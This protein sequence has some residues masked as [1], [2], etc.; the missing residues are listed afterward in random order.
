[1]KQTAEPRRPIEFSR[2]RRG[3]VA[4][5]QAGKSKISIRLDKEVLEHFRSIGEQAGGGNYQSLINDAL[6]AYIQQQSVA[7]AA[8]EVVKEEL[9]SLKTELRQVLREEVAAYRTVKARAR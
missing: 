8:R 7:Q 5:P 3:P 9:G 2:A 4:K 6:R 1:M